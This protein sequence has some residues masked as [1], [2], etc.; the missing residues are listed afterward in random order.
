MALASVLPH[1]VEILPVPG[2]IGPEFLSPAPPV[3]PPVPP[4]PFQPALP[5]FGCH[6]IQSRSALGLNLGR[7]LGI[8]GPLPGQNG[9]TVGGVGFD[10]GFPPLLGR[11]GLFRKPCGESRIGLGP[12]LYPCAPALVQIRI[13]GHPA[14]ISGVLD[15]L[16][17]RFRTDL[18]TG[19]AGQ[20]ALPDNFP[21]DDATRSPTFRAGSD[22][23][24][25]TDGS[26]MWKSVLRH[27]DLGTAVAPAEPGGLLV[28][29]LHSAIR[30]Q[31]RLRRH[32]WR[33]LLGLPSHQK[34]PKIGDE[35][36][37]SAPR[38]SPLVSSGPNKGSGHRSQMTRRPV[39]MP[40]V[41]PTTAAI[42]S[43]FGLTPGARASGDYSTRSLTRSMSRSG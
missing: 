19:L 21:A 14:V 8:V 43:T 37:P 6:H 17:A 16:A 28:S 20:R 27:G 22:G 41:R 42:A 3:G 33:N 34:E 2:G 4:H 13:A 5:M 12:R 30:P 40:C 23:M 35:L 1:P 25:G 18:G 32:F 24:A 26:S 31:H 9:F 7:M 15:L 36:L 29:E 11:F 10:S 38:P 39:A